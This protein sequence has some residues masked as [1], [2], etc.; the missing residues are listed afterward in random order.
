MDIFYR[1]EM[2]QRVFKID[3]KEKF[4]HDYKRTSQ[5]FWRMQLDR[6]DKISDDNRRHMA[7][8]IKVYLGQTHGSSKAIKSLVKHVEP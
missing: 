2:K 1:Q 5:D 7:A 8:A 6:L 4:N 3:R